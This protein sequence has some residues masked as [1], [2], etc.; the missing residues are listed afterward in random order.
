MVSYRTISKTLLTVGLF[1]L[2]WSLVSC[3]STPDSK[4][5]ISQQELDSTDEQIFVGDSLEMSYDPNVIMKRAESFFDKKSYAEAIVEY[6]HFLD[7]HRNHMLAPY[8]QYKIGMSYVAQ[9]KTID[10]DPAPLKE[11]VKAF[12]KLLANY[13]GSRHEKEAREQA[14]LSRERLA[15]YNLFVGQFYYRKE[16]YLA[17]AHR[18]EHIIATFPNL[19]VAGDAMYHLAEAYHNLGANDWARDWLMAMVQN[20]PKNEYRE[21]GRQLLVQL[22]KEHPSLFIAK[23]TTLPSN[24]AIPINKPVLAKRFSHVAQNPQAAMVPVHNVANVASFTGNGLNGMG[25][26]SPQ[27]IICSVG[28]WCESPASLSSGRTPAL[29]LKPRVCQAGQW[30]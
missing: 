9:F 20:Y 11:S 10:R 14:H 30:C 3:S 16:S 29:S 23:A 12:Q 6:K 1:L 28:S 24:P 26:I 25:E 22:Q 7:L 18:F 8:A 5:A 21:D 2:G 4:P 19:D 27:V 15:K 17:A 13:P